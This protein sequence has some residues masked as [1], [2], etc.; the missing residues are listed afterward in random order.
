MKKV[1]KVE[2]KSRCLEFEHRKMTEEYVLGRLTDCFMAVFRRLWADEYFIPFEMFSVEEGSTDLMDIKVRFERNKWD[3]E[4]V[5]EVEAR[6]DY[7]LEKEDEK[8][9]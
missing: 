4:F 1:K 5:I 8:D 7:G 9:S 6:E 2:M 3:G